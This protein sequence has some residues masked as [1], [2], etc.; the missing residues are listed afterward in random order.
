MV[1]LVEDFV[2]VVLLD[3]L[4][5]NINAKE[6]ALLDAMVVVTDVR[7]HVQV[8]VVVQDV[9]ILVHH[10][11][12]VAVVVQEDVLV[13]VQDAETHA[14]EDV[15]VV[16]DAVVVVQTL[17][18]GVLDAKEVVLLDVMDVKEV[19]LEVVLA[20]LVLIWVHYKKGDDKY[21]KNIYDKL[22]S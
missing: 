20:V 5:A 12:V 18:H 15:Q 3:V 1:L 8:V 14:L 13:V 16:M 10:A 11:Q 17:V 6:V 21:G 22:H 7:K 4:V 9:D 19:V 2:Q